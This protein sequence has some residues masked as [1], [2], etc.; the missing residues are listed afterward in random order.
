MTDKELIEKYKMTPEEISAV[1]DSKFGTD[2]ERFQM[3]ADAAQ[4]KLMAEL[5]SADIER[6]S[7]DEIT[8]ISHPFG[9]ED[10]CQNVN[11]GCEECVKI[12]VAKAA[13]DKLIPIISAL[14][15]ENERLKESIRE[16][17]K[18]I[19]NHT[20]D[21]DYPVTNSNWEDCTG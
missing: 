6:L 1:L 20:T 7:E 9:C 10:T 13:E 18:T 8:D 12:M 14:R 15:A 19:H 17:L 4:D 2:S 16:V 21:N 11:G 3:V 5:L